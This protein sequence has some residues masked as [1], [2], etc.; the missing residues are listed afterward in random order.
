M[1]KTPWTVAGLGLLVGTVGPVR[2][3]VTQF[4]AVLLAEVE[5]ITNDLPADSAFQSIVVPDD[6]SVLP[7]SAKAELLYMGM[8]SMLPDG[9]SRARA[10]F[11]DPLLSINDVPQELS[12]EAVSFSPALDTRFD[13]DS[14]IVETRTIVLSPNEITLPTGASATFTSQVFFR[15]TVAM[16]GPSMT[17]DFTDLSALVTMRVIQRFADESETTLLEAAMIVA[18]GPGGSITVDSNG[19]IDPSQLLIQ[20]LSGQDTSVGRV[21]VVVAPNLLLPYTYNA[22]VGDEFQLEIQVEVSVEGLG[23]SRGAAVVLG[24]PF[25]EFGPVVDIVEGSSLGTRLQDIA[26]A[27]SNDMSPDTSTPSVPSLM[28]LFPNCAAMGVE[29]FGLT[30]IAGVLCITTRR[31]RKLK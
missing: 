7:A 19:E 2:G 24:G 18:G 27:A 15:G 20:D 22:V 30:L 28:A 26:N 6:V 11:S 1:K 4:R 14:S 21:W 10:T 9:L 5:R 29:T 31:R 16:W 25:L 12:L 8:D 17:D 13:A 3:A 23:G